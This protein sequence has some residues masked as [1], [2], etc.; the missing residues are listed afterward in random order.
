MCSVKSCINFE[1]SLSL[2]HSLHIKALRCPTPLF[3]LLLYLCLEVYPNYSLPACI[4]FPSNSSQSS[5]Q[6]DSYRVTLLKPLLWLS[7]KP[8][9]QRPK[10]THMALWNVFLPLHL[11]PQPVSL[12]FHSCCSC[13]T[14][15]AA[16]WAK[17]YQ[18]VSSWG[19]CTPFGLFLKHS[20]LLPY[21]STWFI[22]LY[23]WCL[24]MLK[25]QLLHEVY[26][27]PS[28]KNWNFPF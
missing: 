5:S 21:L 15:L 18:T 1:S 26:S 27:D 28:I 6:K 10:I 19:L 12:S 7:T 16:S 23:H 9:G 3:L 22:L 8:K 13:L 24:S 17:T 4:F 20:S 11:W 14:P 25:G 2:G